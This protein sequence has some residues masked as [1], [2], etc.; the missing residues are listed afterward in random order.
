M[1]ASKTKITE[2]DK[3]QENTNIVIDNIL[4]ERDQSF[5]FW[6]QCLPVIDTVFPT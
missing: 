1:N 5:Q 4:V 3:W 6:A 2:H